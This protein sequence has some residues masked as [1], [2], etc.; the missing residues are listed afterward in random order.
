MCLAGRHASLYF[1]MHLGFLGWERWCCVWNFASDRY[2]HS[3]LMIFFAKSSL[4]S[5]LNY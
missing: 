1:S 5:S 3:K 4:Q 2:K